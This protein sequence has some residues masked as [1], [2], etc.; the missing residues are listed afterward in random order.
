LAPLSPLDRKRLGRFVEQAAG[1]GF[2]LGIVEAA[3][4]GDR[5]GILEEVAHALGEGLRSVDVCALPGAEGN[6]WEALKAWFDSCAAAKTPVRVLAL[7]GIESRTAPDWMRQ[8][9]VQRDLFVRDLA[10][11]WL[12][13]I[14]PAT[15]VPLLQTAPDFCDFAMLWISAASPAPA[16]PGLL[17]TEAGTGTGGGMLVNTA[18]SGDLLPLSPLLQEALDASDRAEWEKAWDAL[19]RYD[20]RPPGP[21]AERIRRQAIEAALELRLG[22]LARAEALLRWCQD[23]GHLIPQDRAPNED[24]DRARNLTRC[25]TEFLVG[26]VLVQAGRYGEAEKLLRATLP[27]VEQVFGTEHPSYGTS[28]HNLARVL[29]SQGKY[30]EAETLLRRTLTLQEKALGVEHPSYGTSLHNLANVLQSQGKYAEAETLLRRTLT[31]QEKAL[32]K[33]H[34]SLCPTLANLAVVLAAQS[35]T[36][37]ATAR[38]ALPLLHRAQ[39][40]ATRVHGPAHPDVGQILYL[41]AQVQARL[42]LPQA[43]KTAEEAVSILARGLGEAHPTTQAARQWLNFLPKIGPGAGLPKQ[44]TK[45]RRSR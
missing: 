18:F 4:S 43:R 27:L 1:N 34:P 7:W 22:H 45:P 29:Q 26:Q 30:A 5:D 3:T 32:G 20:L 36:A 41:L 33:D 21:L 14:H 40:I 6:L 8:L 24:P 9:N 35:T 42:N 44:P 10:V 28:L 12:L 13:F 16:S 11:P 19:G 15:R 2:R 17:S 25:E 39:V 23:Q 37:T 38:D 31:L